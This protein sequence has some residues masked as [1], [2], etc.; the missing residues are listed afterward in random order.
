MRETNK[1]SDSQISHSSNRRRTKFLVNFVISITAAVLIVVLVNVITDRGFTMLSK[2]GNQ[3][4]R[5]MRY[6]LTATR[7]FS[8]A[9]QTLKVLRSLEEDYTFVS[10]IN[11]DTA[12][13]QRVND[14][15]NEYALYSKHV[16]AEQLNPLVDVA[17]TDRFYG[18]LQMRYAS[19]LE[20]MAKAVDEGLAVLGKVAEAMVPVEEQLRELSVEESVDANSRL[21]QLLG[22]AAEGM[23]LQTDAVE[24]LKGQ[25]NQLLKQSLPDYQAARKMIEQYLF[26]TDGELI[27][28][29][30]PLFEEQVKAAATP[31]VVKN[32][33][34]QIN[35]QLEVI[36]NEIRAALT[37]LRQAKGYEPY[38][39]VRFAI[40]NASGFVAI[41]GEDQVRIIP[42]GNMYKVIDTEGKL[43]GDQLD[44]GFVGEELLTGALISMNLNP[45]PLVVFVQSNNQP[46]IGQRGHFQFVTQRL[47]KN[48]IRV[49]QWNPFSPNHEETLPKA[50]EGQKVV[51][52]VL[53]FDAVDLTKQNASMILTARK[54]VSTLLKERTEAGDG[55]MVLLA[56]DPMTKIGQ[57]NTILSYLADRWGIEPALDQLILQEQVVQ[58]RAFA[59]IVFQVRDWPADDPVTGP[60]RGMRGAFVLNSP[61]VLK[62]KVGVRQ[63]EMVVLNQANM[64]T[65]EKLADLRKWQE[66]KLNPQTVAP[67]FVTGVIAEGVGENEEAARVVVTASSLWPRDFY[68][69]NTDPNLSPQ[70]VGGYGGAAYPANSELF[71]NAVYWLS[72]LDEL[73]EASPQTQDI[74]RV[75]AMSDTQLLV[76]RWLLIV[77]IPIAAFALGLVIWSV[78]R[79]D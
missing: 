1:N 4:T 15:V 63:A 13:K 37:E 69:T 31:N 72:G 75:G 64:W 73:I 10:V 14:L 74:R 32:G 26:T 36:R 40:Q 65:V 18:Q 67:K 62:D 29:A 54:R 45:P 17:G 30:M 52:V 6:D 41:L 48:N 27:A 61:I 44:L 77:G 34:L 78:R 22:Q 24:T 9:P 3:A 25:I 39:S 58:G 11:P 8:L 16:I 19:H 55:A 79:R 33:L 57:E 53:P 66:E 21:G 71:V 49:A 23:K 20:P 42:F 12:Q 2:S 68:T 70:G 76:Y 51:W 35:K 50:T 28:K 59:N 7:Q 5:Y 56:Y 46:A 60:L 43:A 38:E 47:E